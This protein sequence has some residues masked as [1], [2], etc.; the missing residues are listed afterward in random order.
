ME[1]YTY[2]FGPGTPKVLG[3]HMLEVCPSL[4]Q[5]TPR[6]EIHPL[7][8]GGKEDPV[9]M[10]FT[11]TPGEARV[12]C[13]VDLGDR[14]RLVSNDVSIVTP[15]EDLPQLP[16]AR[17]VWEPHPSLAESAEAWMLAGG[18]HHTVLSSA[19]TKGTLEDFARI[20]DT[21]LVTIDADT[22]R[23]RFAK[24]LQWTDA[25]YRGGARR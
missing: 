21:E 13:L 18:S 10:V 8:I 22:T 7:G 12:V 11:A 24:E 16:V 15:T 19:V 1:D 23:S 4:T 2:H 25:Y 9:R 6:I 5:E 17:A 14:F 3:A 20:S